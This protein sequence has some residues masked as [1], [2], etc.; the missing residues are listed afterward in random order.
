LAGIDPPVIVTLV[1]L[2]LIT[3]P[4]VVEGAAEIV[5]PAGRVSVNGA[6]NV[7]AVGLVLLKVMV[8]VELSPAL[9]V[10]GLNAFPTV[11]ATFGVRTVNVAIAGATLLP[12]LV[13]N[14]PAATVLMKLPPAGAVTGTV[15]VQEPL[16]GI[17]PPVIVTLEVL[18]VMTPPQLVVGVAEIVTPLGKVSVNGADKVAAVALALLKV[19]VRVELSPA[20]IVAGL[21]ALPIVGGTVAG[22]T[23]NVA[24]AGLALLPLLVCKAPAAIESM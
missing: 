4:Q 10:A 22:T 16:A 18:N 11:G 23:V 12:L 13:C 7:A 3:P 6:V 1:V 14:A 24:T 20:L 21:N 5:K 15:I 9:I 2:K 8:R 17:D 19:M